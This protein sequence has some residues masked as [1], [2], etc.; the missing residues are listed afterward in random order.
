MGSL[1]RAELVT[2]LEVIFNKKVFA[3][4]FH[5]GDEDGIKD[6]DEKYIYDFLKNHNNC[7]L[8]SVWILSGRGGNLR[9]A[10]LCSE[11]LRKNLKRYETFVPTVAGSALC[12]FIIQSDK[13]LIGKNSKI[14]Q[15]DP[16][17]YYDGEDLRAIKQLGNADPQKAFLAKNI[18]S[19][20][21]NNVRRAITTPPNV[22]REDVQKISQSKLHYLARMVDMW[23]GK[24]YHESGLSVKDMELM[25]IKFKIQD[26]EIIEKAKN[27]IKECRDELEKE[28]QRFVIQT[29]KIEEKYYGGYFYS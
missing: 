8:D 15:M 13:L 22:F 4:V 5:P 14:T 23:M 24:E 25:G 21:I 26:Q 12:Y 28:D 29:S 16:M 11:L 3:L 7:P 10:I 2:E 17:F 20:V 9:T 1:N 18:Y 19:P 27:L 6:G